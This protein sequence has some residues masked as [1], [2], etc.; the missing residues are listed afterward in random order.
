[1]LWICREFFILSGHVLL[2]SLWWICS[3]NCLFEY[4]SIELSICIICA[5]L[6]IGLP[7]GLIQRSIFDLSHSLLCIM[8]Y[9]K[10]LSKWN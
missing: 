10:S 3:V 6:S 5:N 7:V 1:M 8:L 9:N 4:L 2:Y